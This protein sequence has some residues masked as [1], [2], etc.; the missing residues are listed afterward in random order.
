MARSGLSEKEINQAIDECTHGRARVADID[1]V[2]N[3]EGTKVIGKQEYIECPDCP[4]GD[5]FPRGSFR[6]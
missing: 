6:G 1:D 5:W 4:L 3:R 2:W